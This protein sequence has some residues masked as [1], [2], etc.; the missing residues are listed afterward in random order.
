MS[1]QID[2]KLERT[3]KELPTNASQDKLPLDYFAL[4]FIL[5]VPFWLLGGGKLPL[6]FNLSVGALVTFAP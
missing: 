5:A 6:P 4:V 2:F 3:P 1:T